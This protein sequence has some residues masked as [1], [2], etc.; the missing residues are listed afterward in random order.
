M[1]LINKRNFIPIVCVSFTLI[2]LFKLLWEHHI[3]FTD[4][5]YSANILI[6]LGFSVLI[7]GILALHSY[8][9][10][11]PFIPV[12]LGQYAVTVAIIVGGIYLI[13]RFT[14]VS[15]YAYSDMI[16]SVTIP[17]VVAA[18]VYYVIFFAQIR[19]ANRMLEQMGEEEENN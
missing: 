17:F 18:V 1:K 3:G 11:F 7:T 10:R 6:C 14:E 13:S 16:M 4:P 9:Q 5:Y 2:V 19:K 8:L 15:K 12:F